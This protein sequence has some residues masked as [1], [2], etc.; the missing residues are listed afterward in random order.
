MG[1]DQTLGVRG[2]F[3]TVESAEFE[4]GADADLSGFQFDRLDRQVG[5][6]HR[7]VVGM[8]LGRHL[9]VEI[10]DMLEELVEIELRVVEDERDEGCTTGI[11]PVDDFDAFPAEGLQ[12]VPVILPGCSDAVGPLLRHLVVQ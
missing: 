5:D 1:H 10:P 8:E 7:R 3:A 4:I 12:V 9:D 2:E 11:I 6:Q